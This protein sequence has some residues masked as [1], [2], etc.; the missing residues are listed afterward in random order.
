VGKTGLVRLQFEL[1]PATAAGFDRKN[2]A[3]HDTTSLTVKA[4]PFCRINLILGDRIDS[5]VYGRKSRLAEA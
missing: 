3:L 5:L 2:H 4:A 1:F